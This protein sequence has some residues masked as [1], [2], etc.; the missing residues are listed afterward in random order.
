MVYPRGL[1]DG[2]EQCHHSKYYKDRQHKGSD[3]EPH[4]PPRHRQVAGFPMLGALDADGPKDDRQHGRYLG[5][6]HERH[7]PTCS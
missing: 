7:Q 1:I 2:S 3:A 6:G 4:A 5:V